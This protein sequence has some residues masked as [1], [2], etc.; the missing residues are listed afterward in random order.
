MTNTIGYSDTCFRLTFSLSKNDLPYA[1]N[2]GR[3]KDIGILLS[4]SSYPMA[5]T[6]SFKG[7]D[8]NDFINYDSIKV[9][10]VK[11]TKE[12]NFRTRN[13][14]IIARNVLGKAI[15]LDKKNVNIISKIVSIVCIII[16]IIIIGFITD[17]LGVEK[18][19]SE[20]T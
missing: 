5:S 10:K 4:D 17:N 3:K 8:G 1:N 13:R 11:K 16:I 12:E 7:I 9:S 14:F 18:K 15:S 19:R 20:I 6:N 2:E